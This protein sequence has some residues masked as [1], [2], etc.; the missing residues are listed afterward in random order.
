[1]TLDAVRRLKEVR[2][3]IRATPP[4]NAAAPAA[5]GAARLLPAGTRVLV[6]RFVANPEHNG[7][8]ARVVSFDTRP[9]CRCAGRREGAVA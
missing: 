7:K 4:T 1:M 8:F 2:A 5:A 3:C 6:H 9:V